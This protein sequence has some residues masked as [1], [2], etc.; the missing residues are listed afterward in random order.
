MRNSVSAM[1]EIT[2]ADQP[3]CEAISIVCALAIITVCV[4]D[5]Y[6]LAPM[7]GQADKMSAKA[8]AQKNG[9][10]PQKDATPNHRCKPIHMVI[11]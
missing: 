9:S 11:G 7:E 5:K 6:A 10:S 3:A 8:S 1:S 4:H 2:C